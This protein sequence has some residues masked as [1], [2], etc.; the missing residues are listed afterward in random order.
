[1]AGSFSFLVIIILITGKCTIRRYIAK[2]SNARL[3][4]FYLF[5]TPII[6]GVVITILNEAININ[7]D[8]ITDP[9]IIRLLTKEVVSQTETTFQTKYNNSNL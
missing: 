1:L 9:I 8:A 2:G 4:G 7:S 6:G 5:L 3:I